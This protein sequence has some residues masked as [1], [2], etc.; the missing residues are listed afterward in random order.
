MILSKKE[1]KV[2]IF[3]GYFYEIEEQINDFT[4]KYNYEIVDIKF[5]DTFT[6]ACIIY[7]FSKARGDEN[8]KEN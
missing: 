7:T 8:D 5:T 3:Q 6:K 1:T 4:K 2:K